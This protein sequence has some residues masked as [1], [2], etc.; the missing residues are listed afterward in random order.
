MRAA[1]GLR[2]ALPHDRTQLRRLLDRD[3][4][5]GDCRRGDD[6]GAADADAP[7]GTGARARVA[8]LRRYMHCSACAADHPACL[9]S[10]AQRLEGAHRRRCI[11][12]E[13]YL[14]ICGHGGGVVRWGD[15]LRVERNKA[16]GAGA[17]AP[18]EISVQCRDGSHVLLC[19]G[20]GAGAGLGGGTVYG[21]W[22]VPHA[23]SLPTRPSGCTEGR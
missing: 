16:A 17:G 18:A 4:Y 12:H 8:Q 14:R 1:E 5:C 22:A 11:A 21:T 2:G 7:C 15:L 23:W 6:A 20:A 3:R 9:F 13:G 19:P 10:R